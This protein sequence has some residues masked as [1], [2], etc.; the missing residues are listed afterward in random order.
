MIRRRLLLA[1]AITASTALLLTGCGRS[2][3]TGSSD[4]AQIQLT[5]GPATGTVTVWAQG[6]NGDVLKDF[7]APFEEA[8]PDVTI[9]VTSIPWDSAQNKYQTAV[10]GG[11]TPDIGMLGSDWMSTF[12]DGLQEVPDEISTDDLFPSSVSTTEF[13]GAQYGV[14]WYADT[15]VVFY[16]TD[17]MKAAGVD[18]FPTD[19][20]GFKDLA[21]AYQDAGA[22]YGVQLAGSGWNSFFSNMPFVWSNGGDVMN[23]DQDE[24]TFESDGVADSIDYLNSFWEEGLADRNP[25][26]DQ[27]AGVAAFIDGSAPMFLGGP[28]NMNDIRLAAGDEFADKYALAPVPAADGGTSTSLAGGANFAV[29][30]D[31]KNADAAWKLIQWMSEPDTQVDWFAANGDLPSNQLAWEDPSLSDDKLAAFGAQLQSSKTPPTVP[32]WAEVSAAADGQIERISRGQISPADG[33]AELQSTAES[34]GTG[35]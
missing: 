23:A 3:D 22:D 30:K 27:G 18:E 14:P 7:V 5:D 8:N 31:A 6:Y 9:E 21:A 12:V 1:G 28:F 26:T 4:S 10:A 20:E 33:L 29:F 2:S 19:W 15:R 13:G 24:W 16:R 32:A 25:N 11:V 34:I 35:N 17:L